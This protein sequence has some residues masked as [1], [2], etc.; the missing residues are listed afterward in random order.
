MGKW[1]H[2]DFLY[3]KRPLEGFQVASQHVLL[4]T[5]RCAGIPELDMSGPCPHVVP[6]CIK[7]I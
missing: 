6:A 2:T 3:M 4:L 1:T 7:N 5:L